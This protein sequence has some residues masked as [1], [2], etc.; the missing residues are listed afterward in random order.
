MPDSDHDRLA[1]HRFTADAVDGLRR[2]PA[3]ALIL[4]GE[5]DVHFSPS[6]AHRL[7]VDLPGCELVEIR[8]DTGHLLMEE[9]PERVAVLLRDFLSEHAAGG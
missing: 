1:Q 7:A 6:D 4:W 9:H 3:P 8:P 2:F 5:R